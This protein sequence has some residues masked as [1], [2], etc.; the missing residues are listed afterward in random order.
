MSGNTY[1]G[2]IKNYLAGDFSTPGNQKNNSGNQKNNSSNSGNRKN[3]SS[4]SGNRKNNS[5]NSGNR[6]NNSSN[7]GNRKNNSTN[8]RNTKRKLLN[9]LEELKRNVDREN[10]QVAE[11]NHQEHLDLVNSLEANEQLG[12]ISDMNKMQRE[13]N[14]K[15]LDALIDNMLNGNGQV[16]EQDIEQV[17]Q[18]IVDET[19][20]DLV[21]AEQNNKNKSDSQACSKNRCS[22]LH[23]LFSALSWL[24]LY[25][26]P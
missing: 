14:D 4:N 20:N 8:S 3:N 6:K 18:N 11:M 7:S 16:D 25:T 13:Q 19:R 22:M 5:S 2:M 26:D 1:P 21:R 9:E 24:A 10:T 17:V 15:Q 12:D 23:R